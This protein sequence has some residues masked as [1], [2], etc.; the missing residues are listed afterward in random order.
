MA[1]YLADFVPD[2]VEKEEEREVIIK[3]GKM[4]TNRTLHKLG[5]KK[6]TKYDPEYWGLSLLLT[7]EMAEVALKMGVRKPKTLDE[8]VKLTGLKKEHLE[9]LLEEMSFSGV[10][11]YNWENPQHEKQY[12]LPM[13]VPGSA[14]FSNMNA[15]ILEKYPEMGR[16]FERMSR[17]PLEKITPMVPPGGA[18]IGMHV[19]PVEKAIEMENESI[20]IEHI[21]HWLNK[22][23]G[24]YAASPCSC[25]RSRVTFDEGCADDPEGWCIAVGDMADYVVETG[26]GGRYITREEALAIFKQAE[27]NGF[28]HQITNIDG[29]NKIF[30]ICNCNVNVCYALRTS[31]LFNTPNLSRSAYVARVDKKDCV[32]CGKCV[33]Y[34]PAGA[35]KLGQKLCTK[36]GK[37]VEYKKHILPSEAKWGPHMWDENYRDNNRINCYDTGTAPCKTACPA[38]IAVQGYLKMAAQG[39]YRD[40][41]ALIKKDNPLP[42]ICGRICN[43][44]CEDACTRAGID[45]AIAIDEVKRFIAEQDLKAETRY[46]PK[47]VVPSLE[48]EFHEKIAI[49][50]G[51]PAGLSCAY[52]LAEKG[53]SPTIFEKNQK[54]GGMLVYG[55]PSY[56]LEKDIVQAEIDVITAMGVEIKTGVEVGKDITVE[57]LRAQGY[58]AF[59][60]AIGCQGGRLPGIAGEDAEGVMTAVEFLRTV[61]EDENYP[62]HGK[63]VVIGGGNVAIDAAR[64]SGRCGAESVDMYCLESRDTMPASLE[65]IE[66]AEEEGVRISFGWGPKEIRTEN[67]KVTGIV[68]KRCISTTDSEGRFA[69]VYDEEDILEIPCDRIFFSIGQSIQWGEL[70]KDSKVELGRGNKAV[71]DALTYQTA[72]PDIFVGGDVYSGPK[73]AIDAIAAGK[74]GAISIHRFVRPHSSL[75]IGRNRRDFIALDK[76]NILVEHYDN[77]KRQIPGKAPSVDYKKSFRDESV[78]FT[79]EQVKK[80]T[81]R[82]LGCG[83]SVVDTNKCI[84]CGICT[85]KCEFDAIHLHRE[86]PECSKMIASEEKIKYVLGNGAKQAI[87]LKFKK[88]E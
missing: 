35:V 20:S 64:V 66:E 39:R 14:E 81:A 74:E 87:K 15:T 43:R 79:E 73:F 6:L 11:E 83:A 23:E 46:I 26:K 30:A 33:E 76:E 85:T 24:K 18:G 7:D 57:E 86:L 59:Y 40:A 36:D 42:A 56:K 41:L 3:L 31:Q 10:I 62:V 84:G 37:E 32:A 21:S 25:R 69:P 48:G 71:A 19:I 45:E 63:T 53:Y 28:V 29:E 52:Y 5:L 60:I 55:I 65:E 77:G 22:Y 13:F 34:C 44:R 72:Q 49:I 27:E 50:G 58:K 68:L 75:T 54:A 80:E 51:G 82:C 4:V 1:D 2:F 70:L 38:H 88:K 8:L 9:K 47:K 67:G 78:T 12:V 17:L 61:A 16:F